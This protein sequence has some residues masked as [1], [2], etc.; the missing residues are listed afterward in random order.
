MS[1]LIWKTGLPE[2]HKSVIVV[3]KH[4]NGNS[5]WARAQWVPKYTLEDCGGYEGDSDYNGEDD[6][7]Y[8]PEGW[9]EW[10]QNEDVH[11]MF[12]ENIIGWA[13]VKLPDHIN[14]N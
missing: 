8:W 7:Y 13:E 10:N 11:W 14:E 6:N 12:S 4:P 1:E 9:Y 2:P 3:I 5:H